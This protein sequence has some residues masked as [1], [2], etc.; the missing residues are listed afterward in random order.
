MTIA[1]DSTA[2]AADILNHADASGFPKWKKGDDLTSANALSL[3]TDGNAFDVTGTTAITSISTRGVGAIILLH[4]DGALTLTHHSTNIVLPDATNITTAAGDIAVLHEYASADWRLVS[5][6]RADAAS[7]V[8]SVANGGTG[9]A[10]LTDGGV[11]LGNGTGAIQAMAV[12]GDGYMIV[13]DGTTDPV[14]ENDATLRTSIGVGTG[15]SPQFTAV[16]VGAAT[17]TTVARASAGDINVEGNL[18][19]RAGGTDVPVA[20]GGTGASTLLTNAVLTGNGTSAIQAESDLLF[21]SNKLNPT[22]SAH[23]AAGTTLTVSAGATTA[24][25]SNNQAGGALT[26]QGGQGKGSGAGGAI[27]FQVAN[28]GSSGSSLNSLATAL[29]VNDDSTLTTAGAIELGHAS[30]TTIARSGSGDITIEGN[31]VYRAGGTD[32]PVADGGTGASTLTAGGV[33]LGSGTG[34][35]T[36]MSVLSNGNIV[37]GDGDEDPVALA[38]FTSSTGQLKHERGGIET[39]ISGIAKGGLLA[40]SGTG[41]MAITTVGSEDQVLTVDGSGGI[42]WETPASGGM[43]SLAADSSPQLGGFLDANGNYMQTEKGGDISSASPL[44][45]DTDGDYFD[46]TGTTNYAA[47]TVAADRQFTLQFDGAL[48]MTHHATNL[49]LPGAANI[50]TA[51][52]D[53]GVFQSTGANTVQCISYTKADGTAVVSSGGLFAS[54]AIIADQ[55]AA[56][57]ASG[58]FTQD[59]WRTRDLNDEITD[60]DGIVS[61]SSN[62]FTLAAGSYM[63]RWSAPAYQVQAH[64]TKLLDVTATAD[65]EF[66]SAEFAEDD[67]GGQTVSRSF[68]AAR[69]TPSGSNVYEIQHYCADTCSS[70]GFGERNNFGNVLYYTIVEIYKEA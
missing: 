68:G 25:T 1:S 29:T 62:Q 5:Y 26:F 46:V 31:A 14:A 36:A 2:L 56:N 16:N 45:I 22:A 65:I 42:G 12:L 49:D 67:S 11:L 10:T 48:T 17:D 32:V 28:E 23:D 69:V 47:M 15:D 30:D 21:A 20:D 59:A 39:D 7:G 54:Y 19:Y 3:G 4:F 43:A 64:Q 27:V 38:A 52:G 41:S 8:L 34:A 58:T 51:A 70:S 44:V 50:T 60:P 55:K 35:V 61:I 33:L 40:G 57:G 6:S 13:G 53:V 66:G 18:I 9:A 24:G 37:V 63:I